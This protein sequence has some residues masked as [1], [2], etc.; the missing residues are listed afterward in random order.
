MHRGWAQMDGYERLWRRFALV[1]MI[2]MIM[3]A[4]G[5]P[6]T[7]ATEVHIEIVPI[8]NPGE[9]CWGAIRAGVVIAEGDLALRPAE[10]YDSISFN[11]LWTRVTP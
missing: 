11:D 2:A 10:F 3:L 7:V 9:T 1:G 5:A 4:K 8:N 6:R